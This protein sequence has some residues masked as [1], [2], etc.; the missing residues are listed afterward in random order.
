[1]NFRECRYGTIQV[2]QVMGEVNHDQ[3]PAL[4]A[5]FKEKSDERCPTLVVDLSN[6]PFMD[7]T[8]ISVLLEYLGDASEF[9]G[10][11]CVAGLSERVNDVFEIAQL[12][13]ALPVFTDVA[14]VLT[15]FANG[16]APAAGEQLFGHRHLSQTAA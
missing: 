1:M 5:R 8:G 7:G 11:F 13:K 10:C 14:S 15:E 4:R 2:L 16:R 3:V 12:K 9:G 6:V